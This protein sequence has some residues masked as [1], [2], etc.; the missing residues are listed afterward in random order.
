LVIISPTF[1][2]WQVAV[3]LPPYASIIQSAFGMP[4]SFVW[5]QC[6]R[7]ERV[8]FLRRHVAVPDTMNHQIILGR[9]LW[10]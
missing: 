2:V 4:K 6:D 10:G 1:S 5:P 8:E 3:L 9:L 7:N